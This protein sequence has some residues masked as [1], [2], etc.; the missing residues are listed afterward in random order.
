MS[1]ALNNRKLLSMMVHGS[2][3]F[4]WSVV[5]VG[6]PIVLLLISEDEVVKANAC[7]ALNYG[8]IGTIASAIIVAGIMCTFGLGLF[9]L[10]PLL[11]LIVLISILPVVGMCMV[12]M[13]SDYVFRY[14]LMPRMIKYPSLPKHP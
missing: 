6:V 12:A 10:F 13:N 2:A 8:L 4:S 3:L 5:W 9:L 11:P 1:T 7:E 14:P